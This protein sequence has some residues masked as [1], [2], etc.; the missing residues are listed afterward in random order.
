MNTPP[1][2]PKRTQPTVVL[3]FRIFCLGLAGF[4]ALGGLVSLTSEPRLGMIDT[5]LSDG[6]ESLRD[7]L[8]EEERRKNRIMLVLSCVLVPSLLLGSAL[9]ARAWGHAYGMVI[10]IASCLLCL[11]I[12]FAIPLFIFWLKPETKR[13]FAG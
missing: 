3:L 9:P 8:M 12:V 6:D 4:L 7:Q 5:M 13:Y 2:L 10:L 1:P 11:P